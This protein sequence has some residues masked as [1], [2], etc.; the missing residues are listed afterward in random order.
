LIEVVEKTKQ[1][2]ARRDATI[3]LEDKNNEV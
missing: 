2:V 1:Q 3:A